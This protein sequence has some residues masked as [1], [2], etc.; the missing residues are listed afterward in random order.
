M[1]CRN[2]CPIGNQVPLTSAS[3]DGAADRGADGVGRQQ[4]AEQDAER[5]ERDEAD[6]DQP[7]H[8][9]P[10][11]SAQADAEVAPAA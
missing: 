6:E 2:P 7:G 9:E 8:L 4:V 5:R 10:S 1:S 11:R 3:R